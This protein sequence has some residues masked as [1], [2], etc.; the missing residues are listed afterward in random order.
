MD[1]MTPEE[2]EQESW[3]WA[4]QVVSLVVRPD[5]EGLERAHQEGLDAALVTS[6]DPNAAA[7][8]VM[9]TA[10]FAS[11]LPRDVVIATL[12]RL[13]DEERSSGWPGPPGT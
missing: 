2:H 13:A 11:E 10:V 9:A 6:D 12:D 8:L 3:D 5:G 1:E 7:H 4:T